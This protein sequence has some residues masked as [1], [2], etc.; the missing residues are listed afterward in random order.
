MPSRLDLSRT[1]KAVDAR[2][3]DRRA[4]DPDLSRGEAFERD[5]AAPSTR[6]RQRGGG[7]VGARTLCVRSRI[8]PARNSI[9]AAESSAA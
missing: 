5:F 3:T 6:R 1:L 8:I 7:M 4:W 9:G 2:S